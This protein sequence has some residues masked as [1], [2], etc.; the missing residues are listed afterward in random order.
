MDFI[1]LF[2]GIICA[3]SAVVMIKLSSMHPFWLAGLRV[4]IATIA[5]FPMFLKEARAAE[6]KEVIGWIITGIFPGAALSLHFVTWITSA[7]II[8]AANSTLI[9]NMVPLFMPLM[10]WL[11]NRERISPTEKKATAIALAGTIILVYPDLQ[12]S[13]EYLKGDLLAF[14]SMIFLTLYL[15]LAKEKSKNLPLWG[16]LVP[17][18]FFSGIFSTSTALLTRAPLE[19]T[20]DGNWLLVILLGLIPTVIGHSL[21]N[22]AMKR[23]P[24]QTVSLAN[25][26]QILLG[27]VW[28]ITVF[29]EVPRWNLYLAA[30]LILF[31]AFWVIRGYRN[32]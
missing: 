5:L 26:S 18:Y 11:L 20:T 13:T 25:L 16:Y 22:R 1:L 27:A 12:L 14:L 2:S 32:G 19:L 24:P 15:L 23:L 17:L 3:S 4:F 7:Q 6:R 21:L 28:G 9:V 8:P 10:L 30:S 31:S 29:S